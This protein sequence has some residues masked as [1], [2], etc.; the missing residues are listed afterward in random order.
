MNTY[1]FLQIAEQYKVRDLVEKDL[2]NS[3]LS[4][5]EILAKYYI[6][7]KHPK[8]RNRKNN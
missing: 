8:P 5:E 3:N 7:D 2:L 6:N 1:E 4:Y